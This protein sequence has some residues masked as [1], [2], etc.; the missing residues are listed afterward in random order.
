MRKTHNEMTDKK[1]KQE[2][3]HDEGGDENILCG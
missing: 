3:F 2:G 1:R